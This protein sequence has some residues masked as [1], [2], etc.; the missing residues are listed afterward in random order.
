[1]VLYVLGLRP[2]LD[3]KLHGLE[4]AAHCL[5]TVLIVTAMSLMKVSMNGTT[6]DCPIRAY[7]LSVNL[8]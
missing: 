6:S 8:N 5:E 1:M 4:V 7:T 2:Y 3:W